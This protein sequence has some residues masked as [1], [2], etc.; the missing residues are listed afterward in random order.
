MGGLTQGNADHITSTK[1]DL[2]SA[3]ET[4]TLMNKNL[5]EKINPIFSLNTGLSVRIARVGYIA[6]E[7]F[8][9]LRKQHSV[10]QAF[11]EQEDLAGIDFVYNNEVTLATSGIEYGFR[12]RPGYFLSQRSLLYLLIGYIRTKFDLTSHITYNNRSTADTIDGGGIDFTSINN[13]SGIQLGI[14]L[15][16]LFARCASFRVQYLYAGYSV[17]RGNSSAPI[18][19]AQVTD[20]AE[21]ATKVA[22][23]FQNISIGLEYHFGA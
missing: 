13:D 5:E 18:I 4:L 10:G 7:V 9:D 12:L 8:A 11:A 15:E 19:G 6:F 23:K 1:V 17:I 16:Y 21:S 2:P 14:G 20:T 22:P 3:N